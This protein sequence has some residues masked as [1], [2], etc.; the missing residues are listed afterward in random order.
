MK[1][2]CSQSLVK[3]HYHRKFSPVVL[4]T[5]N[6]NWQGLEREPGVKT[7]P[8]TEIFS[9]WSNHTRT[10]TEKGITFSLCDSA[11]PHVVVMETSHFLSYQKCVGEHWIK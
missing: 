11:L 10:I 6:G 9:H 5:G 7:Q 4:P 8:P 2:K 3:Y 1:T